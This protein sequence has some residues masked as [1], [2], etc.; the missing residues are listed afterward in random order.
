MDS[1]V[2][3]NSI[4]SERPR[5]RSPA[6]SVTGR[7]MSRGSVQAS[8]VRRSVSCPRPRRN[9]MV[10]GRSVPEA[11]SSRRA[12]QWGPLPVSRVAIT[13]Q[14][15]T[16]TDDRTS[17]PL[18]VSPDGARDIAATN[19]ARAIAAIEQRRTN[20]PARTNSIQH[21][22]A[23]TCH[24]GTAPTSDRSLPQ[25]MARRCDRHH[26]N[27][28]RTRLRPPARNPATIGNDRPAWRRMRR[29]DATHDGSQCD[30]HSSFDVAADIP[31]ACCRRR[32]V[33]GLTRGNQR[34]HRAPTGRSTAARVSVSRSR[35]PASPRLRSKRASGTTP[36]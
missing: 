9:S 6:A 22:K 14:G 1:C 31:A 16:V 30:D 32:V 13:C 2:G 33:A 27:C 36:G 24:V 23:P 35:C 4:A 15:P 25:R 28:D 29:R 7:T 19:S 20:K 10:W 17:G 34:A 8:A 21:D 11:P 26:E 3:V 12:M 18:A 5:T